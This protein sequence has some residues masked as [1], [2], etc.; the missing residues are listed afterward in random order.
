MYTETQVKADAIIP[1]AIRYDKNLSASEKLVFGEI[2]AICRANGY[3]SATN[4]YFAEMFDV[5]PA[6][7]SLWI[8]RLKEA[9][10]INVNPNKKM[11]N[12]RI[13]GV[14]RCNAI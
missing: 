14:G 4:K 13:I 8:N 2:D 10:Y 1:P 9:G 3:C 7:V 12:S 11:G 5:D 6:T